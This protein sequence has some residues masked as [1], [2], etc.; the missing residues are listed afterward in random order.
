[1]FLFV[2]GR[3]PGVVMLL[4]TDGESWTYSLGRL[5]TPS[6]L[7]VSLDDTLV[8]QRDPLPAV[9]DWNAAY[10]GANAPAAIPGFESAPTP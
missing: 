2:N 5:S 1:M 3:N 10:T 4:E 6:T 7:T 8:W 9:T